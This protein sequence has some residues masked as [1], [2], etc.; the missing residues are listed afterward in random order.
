M[1]CFE[2]SE[3]LLV[4]QSGF[5]RWQTNNALLRTPDGGAVLLDPGIL[6]GEITLLRQMIGER[7]LHLLIN[8]H[9]H[10]D[11]VMGLSAWPDTPRLASDLYRQVQAHIEARM[12]DHWLVEAG[13]RG[14]VWDPPAAYL[15]PTRTISGTGPAG[16]HLPGW[17]VIPASGHAP[18]LIALY[19]G[20]SATLWAG[21][22]VSQP[23][24]I[25]T[26]WQGY[27]AEYLQTLDR[28]AA[29]P[30]ETLIPGHGQPVQGTAAAAD[31][32]ASNRAYLLQLRERLGR[33]LSRGGDAAEARRACADMQY[34]AAWR[35]VH[36]MNIGRVWEELG[37]PA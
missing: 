6:P 17:E 22:A 3:D 4:F 23:G 24:E 12:R 20:P 1:D 18:D 25:P 14:I 28:L 10:I 26:M 32:I 30:L 31:C 13:R 36:E 33:V 21:D 16:E 15:P 27:S 19:H 29:L 7:P 37:G 8:T 5:R 34:P 2:I 9:A 35:I 11:H